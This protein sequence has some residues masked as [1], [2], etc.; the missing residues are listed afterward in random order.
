MSRV[1]S[2]YGDSFVDPIPEIGKLDLYQMI[3]K[4]GQGTFGVVQ[5]A[6]DKRTG[7]LVAV[8]QLLN[9]L[10]KEGFPITALREITILKQ[11]EHHNILNIN[12]LVYEPPKVTNPADLVT[13]RGTFYTISPYMTSDL[14]GILENPDVKLELNQIKCIMIQLLQGTQFIHEQNFLHRDIKAAN[15]L[16][17]SRGVLKIADF[18]LARLYEGDIPRLGMGPG[19]GEKAYTA[20]VVTRW[21][22]PPEI[23][24]GER[25]YTTAVDLWGIGCV[26]AELFVHKPILVGKSDAHQAQL[27]F[28]LIGPPTDWEKASKL[29]NKTDFSIGLG[30]KRSL[31][32]R[33]ESL[34]PS[35]AVDLLSGL[36]ALDPYKRLNALDALDH[37]FFKSEPLPLR[38]EEMPQFGECH[39][40]DKERFK[41]LRET[42]QPPLPSGPGHRSYLE[43]KRYDNDEDKLRDKTGKRDELDGY[44]KYHE[45][46][47]ISRQGAHN[48]DDA[49]DSR[50][51]NYKGNPVRGNHDDTYNDREQNYRKNPVRSYY[52]D[53]YNDKKPDPRRNPVRSYY[54]EWGGR[55]HG[56]W[57]Q[58]GYIEGD[59]ENERAPN[60]DNDYGE[61]RGFEAKQVYSYIPRLEVSDSYSRRDSP[62][63]LYRNENR[64]NQ[65][66]HGR[67]NDVV[68]Y[69]EK[70]SPPRNHNAVEIPWTKEGGH[71]AKRGSPRGRDIKTTSNTWHSREENQDM[72]TNNSSNAASPILSSDNASLLIEMDYQEDE[73]NEIEKNKEQPV[74]SV[75]QVY[76]LVSESIESKGTRNSTS[77]RTDTANS[78]KSNEKE[79]F[80]DKG[81]PSKSKVRLR[82][83]TIVAR[84]NAD[85]AGSVGN[86]KDVAATVT[87]SAIPFADSREPGKAAVEEA[88]K[89]IPMPVKS[90]SDEVKKSTVRDGLIK[91]KASMVDAHDPKAI[92]TR[93]V[94]ETS[95]AKPK[96]LILGTPERIFPTGPKSL[97]NVDTNIAS[98]SGEETTTAPRREV[99]IST[100][101]NRTM[102][103]VHGG[104]SDRAANSRSSSIFT[105]SPIPKDT[106]SESTL[107]K[108]SDSRDQ[109]RISKFVSSGQ[110]QEAPLNAK[111]FHSEASK[112]K[113]IDSKAVPRSIIGP[114]KE[115][116]KKDMFSKPKNISGPIVVTPSQLSPLQTKKRSR[117]PLESSAKREL[118]GYAMAANKRAKRNYSNIDNAILESDLSDVEDFPVDNRSHE[119]YENLLNKAGYMREPVYRKHI[120]EKRKFKQ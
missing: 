115:P 3:E 2:I 71:E 47:T 110:V 65:A 98:K 10:A 12:E 7:E 75:E 36:L 41:K 107:A 99:F 20:L 97:T 9:H 116:V 113:K 69:F 42:S 8:K 72:H 70:R 84:A 54:D 95:A 79:T 35:S 31:E 22:R 4:L 63:P 50:E 28:E 60:K 94:S 81:E 27:I 119:L 105:A 117:N 90:C 59:Y 76:P 53:T 104:L 85:S 112:V 24:L 33:F 55:S 78:E 77:S 5:K 13:N 51:L 114:S 26:F 57:R 74:S 102:P 40:I 6:R 52:D 21:Y 109:K 82:D 30:C 67:V 29:P 25:K 34:M 86:G 88:R 37:V 17:D 61:S 103:Y 49:F 56:S 38:P 19:G 11:L 100:T 106:K 83:F 108:P 87:R 45:R 120:S 118:A 111:L 101:R 15:I 43:G 91:D 80:Q 1:G 48:S 66:P 44:G 32:R 62:R 96:D 14:V 64:Y 18:G 73:A 16:I 46:R 89:E 39:E 92:D 23:L 68:N 58:N 93:D